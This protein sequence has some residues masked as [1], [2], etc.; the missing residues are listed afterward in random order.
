[1]YN[2]MLPIYMYITTITLLQLTYLSFGRTVNTE[3]RRA[4]NN[5]NILNFLKKID[6]QL[7]KRVKTA[8]IRQQCA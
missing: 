7:N 8:K 3:L 6:N 4:V 1:M 5:R 2:K